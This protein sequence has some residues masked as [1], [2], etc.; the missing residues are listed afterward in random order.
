MNKL[1][2]WGGETPEQR[3][4]QLQWEQELLLEQARVKRMTMI[5]G[6]LSSESTGFT[7]SF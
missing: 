6:G 3:Q 7:P 5:G 2:N 4:A 1:F